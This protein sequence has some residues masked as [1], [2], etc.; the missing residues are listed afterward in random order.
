MKTNM[1]QGINMLST[2]VLPLLATSLLKTNIIQQININFIKIKNQRL[3]IHNFPTTETIYKQKQANKL[4]LV[5]SKQYTYYF[6]KN[7]VEFATCY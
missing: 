3:L 6:N 5:F 7:R 2:R 1:T 4:R